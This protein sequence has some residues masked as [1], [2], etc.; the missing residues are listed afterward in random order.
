VASG[1]RQTGGGSTGTSWSTR[2]CPVAANGPGPRCV[3][4]S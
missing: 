2:S 4:V 1:S 3:R